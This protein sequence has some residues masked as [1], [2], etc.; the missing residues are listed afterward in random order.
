MNR[1]PAYWFGVDTV[2]PCLAAVT[3]FKQDLESDVEYGS[4][5]L[6]WR[7]S[8][9]TDHWGYVQARFTDFFLF[10]KTSEV[11]TIRTWN[12]KINRIGR[13]SSYWTTKKNLIYPEVLL[14]DNA[15]HMYHGWFA[16]LCLNQL[17]CFST[18]WSSERVCEGRIWEILVEKSKVK[19]VRK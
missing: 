18:E 1:R 9:I 10:D 8:E 19:V 2:C 14:H 11:C 7:S 3:I 15:I 13:L 17:N 6:S 4:H 16:L 12:V 5:I